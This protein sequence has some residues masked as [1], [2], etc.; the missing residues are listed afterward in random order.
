MQWQG[1]CCPQPPWAEAQFE[2]PVE[3]EPVTARLLGGAS[4]RSS[5]EAQHWYPVARR[6]R[7]GSHSLGHIHAWHVCCCLQVLSS[8]SWA[9]LATCLPLAPTL[10]TAWTG[11]SCCAC[12]MPCLLMGSLCRWPS[13][14]M[15]RTHGETD[16]RQQQ[17]GSISIS[18]GSSR[19]AAAAAGAKA[20]RATAAAATAAG[21]VVVLGTH[22]WLPSGLGRVCQQQL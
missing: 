11:P 18:Q 10:S 12:A 2:Q 1:G 6:H 8:P 15:P 21:L 9:A 7:T 5:Y 17:Q 4:P 16:R 20:E 14:W 3:C 19:V 13:C 22:C